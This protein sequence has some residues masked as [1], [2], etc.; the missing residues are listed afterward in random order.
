MRRKIQQERAALNA[1][2]D[3]AEVDRR[4]AEF[5]KRKEE[6][7]AL[8]RSQCRDQINLD[9]Q[10]RDKPVPEPEED[11]MEALRRALAGRVR[12]IIDET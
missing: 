2:V 3:P 11:P 7:A 1:T 8:R 6:L 10:K 5:R 4:K 9:L 12:T